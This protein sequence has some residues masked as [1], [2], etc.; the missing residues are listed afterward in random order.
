[1]EMCGEVVERCVDDVQL[2]DKG[3][4]QAAAMMEAPHGRDAW[5]GGVKVSPD[6]KQGCCPP[7]QLLSSE[8]CSHHH[9]H[10]A[11]GLL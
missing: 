5:L 9:L 6:A 4:P 11:L 3:S 1:V 7:R 10:S 8:L 2:Y